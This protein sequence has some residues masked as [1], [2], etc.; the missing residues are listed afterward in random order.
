MSNRTFLAAAAMLCT[1]SS[2]VIAAEAISDSELTGWVDARVASYAP[3]AEERRFD[4]IGWARD[5]R[6]ALELS[7][8]HGRPVFL[9]TQDGR[10]NTGR[11]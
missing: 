7:Q 3:T 2:V 1:M 8:E 5:L 4:E 11:C 6:H 9:F 10:I